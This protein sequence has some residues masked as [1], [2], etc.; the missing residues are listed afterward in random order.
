LRARRSARVSW[1]GQ[2]RQ[3]LRDRVDRQR[4]V[5]AL[6]DRADDA[7]D[8][9]DVVV[10]GSTGALLRGPRD[11]EE[12]TSRCRIGVL[13]LRLG[14]TYTEPRKCARSTSLPTLESGRLASGVVMSEDAW[15]RRPE[16]YEH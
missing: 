2:G 6:G 10:P 8:A 12:R 4:P 9:A 11:L 14:A 15:A 13:T 16:E 1:P 5:P 7:Q 3:R